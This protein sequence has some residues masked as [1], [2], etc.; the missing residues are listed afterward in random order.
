MQEI[1]GMIQQISDY[2]RKIRNQR[3]W[4]L[5]FR[6]V[7]IS[8]CAAAIVL[9]LMAVVGWCDQL[10]VEGTFSKV[11][12]ITIMA[13]LLVVA[14]IVGLYMLKNRRRFNVALARLDSLI[15]R[16]E[17]NDDKDMTTA[18]INREL[19]LIARILETQTIIK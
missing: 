6:T 4:G 12:L 5:I 7:A 11:L 1:G 3:N 14:A 15:L 13:V 19:Q 16:L 9:A 2:R 8:L 10:K 18:A 17:I